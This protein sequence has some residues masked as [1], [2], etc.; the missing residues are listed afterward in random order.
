[1]SEQARRQREAAAEIDWRYGGVGYK[2]PTEWSVCGAIQAAIAQLLGDDYAY[3]VVDVWLNVDN[4]DD[5]NA[6]NRLPGITSAA[7]GGDK[8]NGPLLVDILSRMPELTELVVFEDHSL[9]PADISY[10]QR[11]P[12]LRKVA[13]VFDNNR[14][15]EEFV[16]ETA[17]LG[18]LRSLEL[19][20]PCLTEIM[21]GHLSKATQMQTILIS[22]RYQNAPAK[23]QSLQ[24][25]LPHCRI[26]EQQA[27][28]F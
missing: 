21:V 11:A 8:L 9:T 24:T 18:N 6:L 13:L 1:M 5:F 2:R 7:V 26:Y 12:K 4:T 16:C 3:R 10:V 19:I 17:R 15:C 23:V 14:I 22:P 27:R 25:A 20:C 28:M